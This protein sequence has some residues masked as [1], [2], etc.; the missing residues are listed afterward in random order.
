MELAQIVEL[1]A[2][3][4]FAE[5]KAGARTPLPEP[6]I[7][8]PLPTE[9]RHVFVASERIAKG[10]SSDTGGLRI[11]A[12]IPGDIDLYAI[13]LF[14]RMLNETLTDEIRERRAWTYHISCTP[15]N[16]RHFREIA[17]C[18][19][20]LKIGA[21][22]EIEGVVEQCISQMRASDDLLEQA[23]RRAIQ[24]MSLLDPT[25]K[26]IRNDA[27]GELADYHR[28]IT[29]EEAMVMIEKKNMDDIRAI[30][31]WLEPARRWTLLTRP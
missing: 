28:I 17:I 3:S 29:L 2:Q 25:G 21:M 24:S 9:T 4:S 14:C 26:G 6:M 31:P 22:D 27:V 8:I 7:N 11:I 19:D 5:Q 23:K 13:R 30:L 18:C 15:Y 1:V 12:R 10:F 20:A 16:Y